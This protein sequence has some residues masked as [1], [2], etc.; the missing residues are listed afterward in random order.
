VS[1]SVS[2]EKKKEKTNQLTAASRL[3]FVSGKA[4]RMQI[5]QKGSSAP[6]REKEG[7]AG[8]KKEEKKKKT[9]QVARV[10]R[11][12][13]PTCV[14]TRGGSCAPVRKGEWSG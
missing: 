4:Q 7:S 14:C 10:P 1:G 2:E 6:V 8:K 5:Q 12:R 13:P 3:G 11:V 9:N